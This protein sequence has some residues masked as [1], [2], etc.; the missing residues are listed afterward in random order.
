[1]M[2]ESGFEVSLEDACFI[3]KVLSDVMRTRFCSLM[4]S[5]L[6]LILS[7]SWE[8]FSRDW[9]RSR[10]SSLRLHVVYRRSRYRRR[11]LQE[12]RKRP[13]FSASLAMLSARSPG[14]EVWFVFVKSHVD[15]IVCTVTRKRWMVSGRR[16][17][18]RRTK[19]NQDSRQLSR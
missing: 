4:M 17:V 14:K 18:K 11:G 9:L 15:T 8:I 2:L 6:R 7:R 12:L 16:F 10:I 19:T 13:I 3:V 1:M 5:R